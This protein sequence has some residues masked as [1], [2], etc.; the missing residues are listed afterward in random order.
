MS[1]KQKM[2]EKGGIPHSC[3]EGGSR[4][5]QLSSLG[6]EMGSSKLPRL[7]AREAR[8]GRGSSAPGDAPWHLRQVVKGKAKVGRLE[9]WRLRQSPGRE[10]EAILEGDHHF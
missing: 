10:V 4:P 2:F 7:Q 9:R 1:A 3:P 5:T 8:G 6:D